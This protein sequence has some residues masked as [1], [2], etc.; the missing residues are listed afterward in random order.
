ME[1]FVFGRLKLV[2]ALR[3]GMLV[4]LFTVLPGILHLIDTFLLLL[5]KLMLSPLML[6]LSLTF[7]YSK[8]QS[9]I[10]E[11][12]TMICCFLMLRL[13]MKTLK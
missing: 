5:C 4:V 1:Q 3:F 2:A 6:F 8:F 11:T 13:G 7:M 10:F 9:S 12:E